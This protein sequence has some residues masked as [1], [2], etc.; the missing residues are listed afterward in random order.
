MDIITAYGVEIAEQKPVGGQHMHD[1]SVTYFKNSII[2]AV[3]TGF[4]I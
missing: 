2:P 1:I 3:F 4:N